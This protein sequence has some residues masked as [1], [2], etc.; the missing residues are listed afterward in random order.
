MEE[1][2]EHI[3]LPIELQQSI[4]TAQAWH[5]GIIPKSIEKSFLEFYADEDRSST[6]MVEELEILFG[7][8]VTLRHIPS[9]VI[10]RTL[11]KYYRRNQ[12]NSSSTKKHLDARHSDD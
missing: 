9:S 8:E 12:L 5:Y 3:T 10:E 6:A 4:T 1:T 7:K 11:G 2:L